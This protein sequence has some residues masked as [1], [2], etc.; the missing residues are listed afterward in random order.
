[1]EEIS[2]QLLFLFI[3]QVFWLMTFYL[4]IS[5]QLLFLFIKIHR[6]S[7]CYSR[8]ISIQ[9]LFLFILILKFVKILLKN[10]NTT[11]VFIYLY[12][13]EMYLSL[14]PFQYNSCF[15]L[16][17]CFLCVKKKGEVI[18]IQ[19]LF[20]F[21][22]SISEF[23]TSLTGFQ[24]NSCFYL[25][26]VFKPFFNFHYI[27][28]PRYIQRF[29]AFFPTG[30]PFS[31]LILKILCS[32]CKINVLDHFLN[33]A[34]WENIVI[35]GQNMALFLLRPVEFQGLSSLPVP[36]SPRIVLLFQQKT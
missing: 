7:L 27:S 25:S 19:L 28:K 5:I 15:Y 29:P 32:P 11:L 30:R 13:S 20:L 17:L 22:V 24:Y 31:K 3:G 4:Y 10:F 34:G 6:A 18:S 1:M 35:F 9:L 16:S 21:I 14:L 12:C 23:L 33:L 26:N 36:A 8:H 2:I